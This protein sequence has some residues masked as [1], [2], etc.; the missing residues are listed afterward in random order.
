MGIRQL[1]QILINEDIKDKRKTFFIAKLFY[2]AALLAIII[3][4]FI[5]S[6]LFFRMNLVDYISLNYAKKQSFFNSLFIILVS[7]I[8][9][10]PFYQVYKLRYRIK[11]INR[12]IGYVKQGSKAHTF[13]VRDNYKLKITLGKKIAKLFPINT[14]YIILDKDNRPFRLPVSSIHISKIKKALT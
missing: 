14:L 3:L 6:E 8:F 12:L 13:E 9:L 5:Y 7:G 4:A 10:F 2:I 1:E 11:E